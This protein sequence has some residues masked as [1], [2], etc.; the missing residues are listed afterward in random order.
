M[1]SGLMV[2]SNDNGANGG[3]SPKKDGADSILGSLPSEGSRRAKS[4]HSYSSSSSRVRTPYERPDRSERSFGGDSASRASKYSGMKRPEGRP[5]NRECRVYVGNLAYE[6]GWQDL[7]DFMR[8]VGEV[9]F[10]DI[11]TQAGGRSKVSGPI[12]FATIDEAQRAIKELNDT[13]LWDREQEA[14][15]G[16]GPGRDRFEGGGRGGGGSGFRGGPPL[17]YIV[18]WQDLKDLFRSAGN[19]VRADIMEGQDGRSKGSGTVMF[20]NTGEARNAISMFDNY[21]W[22]GR[23]L[24]VREFFGSGGPPS[25]GGGRGPPPAPYGRDFHDPG[26]DSRFYG[27]GPYDPYY[28]G[29]G[30]GGYGG[31][32]NG[33]GGGGPYPGYFDRGGFGG[34]DLF[35]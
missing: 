9:V 33:G 18:A 28:G 24:E 15:F 27:R 7:K 8:K 23:R 12:G 19:V 25:G 5:S 4:P 32:Y 34:G 13:H 6:V 17:P 22:H 21:E 31:G 11:L 16:S 26:Y 3:S 29:G 20:D 30:G 1:D 10:A 2:D 14:K 35:A